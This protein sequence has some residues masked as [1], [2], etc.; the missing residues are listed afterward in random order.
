MWFAKAILIP[1]LGR[2]S[3]ARHNEES[4][5]RKCPRSED[6]GLLDSIQHKGFFEVSY[7]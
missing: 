3:A 4:V 5:V 6:S 1:N 7:F 2:E